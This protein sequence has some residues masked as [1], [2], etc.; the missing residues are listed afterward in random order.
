MEIFNVGPW[1]FILIVVLALVIFGPERMVEYSKQAARLIRK[2]I[3]SPFWRDLISTTEEIK[4]IPQQLVKEANLEESLK[5]IS[6]IRSSLK[7]PVQMEI[8]AGNESGET[9]SPEGK[10]LP[11]KNDEPGN[12]V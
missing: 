6:E 3:R 5:E 10:I 9:S 4:S 7:Q 11:P 2:I 8:P 1:E 12:P